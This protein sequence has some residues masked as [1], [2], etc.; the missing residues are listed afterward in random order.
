M[1]FA[2]RGILIDSTSFR[3]KTEGPSPAAP[4]QA[5]LFEALGQLDNRNFEVIHMKP[6]GRALEVTLRLT[7]P[8][9]KTAGG[10]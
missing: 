4:T 6:V 2:Y 1:P 10:L 7:L 3:Q 8:A 5:R 9:Q